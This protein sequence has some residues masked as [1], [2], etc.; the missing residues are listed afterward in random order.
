MSFWAM[1][2]VACG[3]TTNPLKIVWS[4]LAGTVY[5][6]GAA[7]SWATRT[8]QIDSTR[9]SANTDIDYTALVAAVANVDFTVTGYIPWDYDLVQAMEELL[10][11]TLGA[12]TVD[13]KGRIFFKVYKPDFATAD[14]NF[15]DTKKVSNLTYT[16]DM[17]DMIN[18]ISVK[19]R[20]QPV[21][22]WSDEDEEQGLDG[23]YV[24]IDQTSHDNYGQWFSQNFKNRW[25]NAASTHMSYM[26]QHL[27]GK[28]G[29]PPR[30]FQFTTGMD[31]V[32][33]IPGDV[34][35]VTDEKSG[36]T[37]LAIEIMKKEGAYADSPVS[38][39]FAADDQNSGGYT[40]S[41]LGSLSDE[42]DGESPQAASWD[43][44]TD[45]DK[46]FCYLGQSAAGG[47]KYYLFALPF[48][49]MVYNVAMRIGVC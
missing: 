10:V 22:P 33:M 41:F 9:S 24:S 21:W 19:Y 49:L 14:R 8:P 31:G 12:T 35:S 4:I 34:C 3:S 44:A 48:C 40:W 38:I 28:Y 37:A 17:R 7:E 15:A 23:L 43:N 27:I 2:M 36:Y 6:S 39:A 42:G 29:D 30:R 13:G 32:E 46:R 20:K 1:P 11:M 16:R 26:A 18:W 45:N 5:D 25:Y 47:P